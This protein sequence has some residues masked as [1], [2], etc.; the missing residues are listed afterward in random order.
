M[1]GIKLLLEYNWKRKLKHFLFVCVY[2]KHG[3]IRLG[4][5]QGGGLEV[6][7]LM[8]MEDGYIAIG[9]SYCICC[10]SP[11]EKLLVLL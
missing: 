4:A 11:E 2:R 8:I 3:F 5:I 6:C 10:K 7:P 9:D 1:V